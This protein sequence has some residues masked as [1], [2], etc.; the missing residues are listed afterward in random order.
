M[1]RK[2]VKKE[3]EAEEEGVA[4]GITIEVEGK[5]ANE[6]VEDLKKMSLIVPMRSEEPF[7]RLSTGGRLKKKKLLK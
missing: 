2:E 6:G 5:E 4:K 3:G 1:V 7:T